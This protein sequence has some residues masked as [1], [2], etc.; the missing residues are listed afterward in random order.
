MSDQL[1]DA[2]RAKLLK[3]L[4]KFLPRGRLKLLGLLKDGGPADVDRLFRLAAE[5]LAKRQLK[6][7]DVTKLDLSLN[8][9]T[10]AFY[11]PD[12]PIPGA[13]PEGLEEIYLD[14][15]TF[16]VFG[17]VAV[18]G[19]LMIGGVMLLCGCFSLECIERAV[20]EELLRRNARLDVRGCPKLVQPPIEVLGDVWNVDLQAAI[21]WWKEQDI[22]AAAE[23]VPIEQPAKSNAMCANDMEVQ[24]NADL[25]RVATTAQLVK[26]AKAAGVPLSKINMCWDNQELLDLAR[27]AED[28]NNY[29]I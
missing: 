7:G 26:R 6:P 10:F 12:I 14:N 5:L 19:L 8:G 11:L 18:C 22:G 15:S 23:P 17:N 28:D 21:D 29:I 16:V 25:D 3:Q 4:E 1:D 27:Q 9:S 20:F 13:A 24:L 2:M